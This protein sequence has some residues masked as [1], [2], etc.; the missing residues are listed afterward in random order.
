MSW[1]KL[2]ES[3]IESTYKVTEGLLDLI[4]EGSLNWKPSG[5]S[6]WM[7]TGQL[8][9]HTGNGCGSGFKGFAT[10]DWG[11]PE[12]VDMSELPPEEMI[13][14]AEKLPTVGSIAEAREMLA[15]DKQIAIEILQQTSDDDMAN[16]ITTAPWDPTEM[17][18]GHRF[19]Q[20]VDHL[21]SHKAQLYYYLKLQDKP[22]NTGHLWGM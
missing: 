3:E 9:H 16:K 19:K 17:A 18:L 6:N 22:V 14:P 7:T 1:R 15:K 20:M 11:L 8:L 21:A 13:P 4:D 2:L 5:G 10:G 12:G